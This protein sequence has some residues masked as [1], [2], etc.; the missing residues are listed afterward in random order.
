MPNSRKNKKS[1]RRENSGEYAENVK[2][3]NKGSGDAPLQAL[4]SVNVDDFNKSDMP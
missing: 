4:R 1:S 2:N 3:I